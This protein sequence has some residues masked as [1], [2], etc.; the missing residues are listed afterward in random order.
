MTILA[1]WER[2]S[3]HW[4]SER[5]TSNYSNFTIACEIDWPTTK[6]YHLSYLFLSKR[7]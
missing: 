6:Q 3:I 5:E 7:K 2:F 4:E 1:K